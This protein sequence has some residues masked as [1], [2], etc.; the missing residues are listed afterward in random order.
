M[1]TKRIA[2]LPVRVYE[3]MMSGGCGL[4]AVRTLLGAF[5]VRATE[6][7]LA[8][9]CRISKELGITPKAIVRALKKYGFKVVLNQEQMPSVCWRG[10][11][12]WI[13]RGTPV[14]VDWFAA[15][16]RCT[17]IPD[18][19][20]SV[21]IGAGEDERGVKWI[22]LG[23][24]EFHYLADRVQRVKWSEFLRAWFDF[25]GRIPTKKTHFFTRLWIA[26]YLSVKK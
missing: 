9:I 12:H 5:G 23:N 3:H 21:I 15:G 20:Y 2:R 11:T 13:Q 1:A 10:I 19:H 26:P 7:E 17:A 18:G 6:Q 22:W 16:K 8:P 14:L 25:H 24:P 4:G